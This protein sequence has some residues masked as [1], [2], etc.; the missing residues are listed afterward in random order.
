[1]FNGVLSHKFH[2][3]GGVNHLLHAFSTRTYVQLHQH[4]RLQ[5]SGWAAHQRVTG[6]I[7]T[8]TKKLQVIFWQ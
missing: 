4:Q 6:S 5:H 3:F 8:T 1:M 7:S 2:P